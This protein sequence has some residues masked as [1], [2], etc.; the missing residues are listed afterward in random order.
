MC[1]SVIIW[2][3]VSFP[4]GCLSLAGCLWHA[5]WGL[6]ERCKVTK[7]HKGLEP[8]QKSQ[9][10]SVGGGRC[11][12]WFRKQKT[13]SI[14]P[15]SQPPTEKICWH[16]LCHRG[17]KALAGV[18]H[19]VLICGRVSWLQCGVG[20]WG[21]YLRTKDGG[22]KV[23]LL[24]SFKKLRMDVILRCWVPVFSQPM[25]KAMLKACSVSYIFIIIISNNLRLDPEPILGTLVMRWESSGWEARMGS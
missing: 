2:C 20:G 8:I 10:V 12:A 1:A 13:I 5:G 14:H 3:F 25:W 24:F 11:A 7:L 19:H 17:V 23:C 22:L 15:S 21:G 6:S 16:A 9:S 18:Q 4:A